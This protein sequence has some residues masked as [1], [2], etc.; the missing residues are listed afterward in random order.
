MI[1]KRYSCFEY[2][3]GLC[4]MG[5]LILFTMGDISAAGGDSMGVSWWNTLTGV[6][7]LITSILAEALMVNYQK[8]MF[9]NKSSS[10]IEMS[11]YVSS[12]GAVLL[13]VGI[14]FLSSEFQDAIKF[15]AHGHMECHFYALTF[16]VFGFGGMIGVLSLLTLTDPLF[17]GLIVTARKALTLV[18]SFLIF[19][20]P[21][22]LQHM[23]GSVLVF[24]SLFLHVYISHRRQPTQL[25]QNGFHS[26]HSNNIN[27]NNN[28]HH[29]HNHIVSICSNGDTCNGD[30]TLCNGSNNNHHNHNG[31]SN[32]G[33][34]HQLDKDEVAQRSVPIIVH[35][36][37]G[38]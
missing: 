38:V 30:N 20:K 33:H 22:T 25:H 14:A 5:G 18:F 15:M 10:P 4:T 23:A 34:Q 29:N 26:T 17:V 28:N 7:M 37:S 2:M 24:G 11:L 21:I 12:F 32:P 8:K 19:P 9:L 13:L 3:L 27:S 1:N 16:S 31:L 35:T 36:F 6:G